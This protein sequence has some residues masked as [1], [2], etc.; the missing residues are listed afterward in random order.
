M[1]RLH[2][3]LQITM[4]TCSFASFAD[5]SAFAKRMAQEH[6]AAVRLVRRANE[7]VVEGAFPAD[8]SV[9]AEPVWLPLDTKTPPAGSA[10]PSGSIETAADARLCVEC[11]VVIP[12]ARVV[13]VPTVSRCVKCQ[14]VFERTYDTRPHIDEGL[15]GTRNDNKKMRGQLWGDTRNRGRGR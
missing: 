1:G 3:T 11:G 7:F 12:H 4:T 13:A 15:A 2:P 6:K 8:A 5:A 10:T 9:H 14:S